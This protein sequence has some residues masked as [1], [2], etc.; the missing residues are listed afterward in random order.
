MLST[1]SISAFSI[2]VIVVSLFDHLKVTSEPGS[3]APC[4]QI[5]T[6]ALYLC[7]SPDCRVAVCPTTSVL[8]GPGK[9]IDVLVR[10]GLSYKDESAEF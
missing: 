4:K 1:F 8:I 7:M 9:V 5:W 10:P 6:V 2:L 3:H